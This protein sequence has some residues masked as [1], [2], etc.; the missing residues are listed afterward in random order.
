[1]VLPIVAYGHPVLRK[2]GEDITPEYPDLQKLISDMWDTLTNSSGVGLAAQQVNRSIRLFL[3]DTKF[4]V[5]EFEEADLAK[6][7]DEEPLK[8][9]FIN[10]HKIEESGDLWPYSEGC[11]SIPRIRE[12]VNRPQRIKLRYLDENFQPHER[13]F[14][15]IAARVIQHEY[16]HIEGKLFIDYLPLIKKRLIKKKLDDIAAGKTRADYKM[17]FHK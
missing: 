12:D 9:V 14:S 3:V 13:E 17:L 11:L 4:L 10:A 15:G 16:D 8:Q 5:D 6:Y 7:P 1:M 2:V